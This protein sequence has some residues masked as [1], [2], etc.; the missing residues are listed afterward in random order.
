[1]PSPS[2]IAVWVRP[3]AVADAAD[4]RP[5]EDFLLGHVCHANLQIVQR[6]RSCDTLQNLQIYSQRLSNATQIFPYFSSN[7]PIFLAL[8]AAA[9]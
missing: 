9:M 8:F 7:M 3:L 5:G 1:M 6:H 4:A 2:A